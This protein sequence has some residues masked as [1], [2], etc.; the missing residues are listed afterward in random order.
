MSQQEHPCPKG[1]QIF[2]KMLYYGCGEVEGR[3]ATMSAFFEHGR[4]VF[5]H[6]VLRIKRVD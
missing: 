3:Y 5:E 6:T 4:T 2:M 1:T